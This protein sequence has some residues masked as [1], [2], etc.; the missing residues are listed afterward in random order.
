MTTLPAAD[1]SSRTK[2]I[3]PANKGTE[4]RIQHIPGNCGV[5]DSGCS[6]VATVVDG[7]L[8]GVAPRAGHPAGT[9]CPRGMHA[10]DVVYSPDRILTPLRRVGPKG[11]GKFE[12]ITW[13]DAL[14]T[15]AERMREVADVHGPQAIATYMGRGSFERSLQD[16]FG[17][18][19]V[20][21]SSASS[22]FFPLG[23][24]N[25]TG[26][27]A[28]CYVARA[29][30]APQTTVGSYWTDMFDDVENADLIVV[31]GAN[32][33]TDSPPT[34]LRRILR[35]KRRGARVVCIDH[36]YTETAKAAGAQW[37]GIRPGTDG[38]L[39]L[40]M[41]HV[42]IEEELYDRA[43]VEQ[44]TVGFDELRTYVQRFTPDEVERITWVPAQTVRELARAIAAANG[45]AQVMYTGLEY[46]DSGVQN[47]RAVLILWALAGQMD[48]PG[49]MNFKMP[50]SEFPIHRTHVTPPLD[51]EPVGKS[52]FPLY[53]HFRNEAHSMA[54]PAAILQDDPYPVRAMLIGGASMLTSYPQPA[55]WR[56][57]FEALDFLVVVDHFLTA[58]AL[59]ADIVLPSATMFEAE[60]YV[61][62]GNFIQWRPRIIEPVG[63]ARG[64][65]AIYTEIAQRL[66]YGHL[67]PQS[68]D[69]LLAFV[70]Q[71]SD[72]D[73]ETLRASPDGITLPLPE[74]HYRKWETGL[75]RRG[76]QAGL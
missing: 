61:M 50:G 67:Y 73:V 11:V 55:L 75:L 48:V 24:P 57:C 58:D 71:D 40:G 69:E 36:R 72:I 45:A 68:A 59:Y 12:P 6:I 4:P 22:L 49:G 16:V 2:S 35:A 76:R 14:D 29:F 62:R 66:G 32:P 74:M 70:L 33:A 30:L 17:P 63:E 10:V 43:F 54:L 56:R 13:D 21:E 37:V 41:L 8:T 3:S 26:V 7:V 46:T 44:W 28:I 5:C 65:L 18:A 31:W 64:D 53:Y 38:A 15:V 19:G 23:S 20:R 25:T 9:C 39:A 27:G 51:V 60:S 34:A 42:L 52:R 47:I 1:R